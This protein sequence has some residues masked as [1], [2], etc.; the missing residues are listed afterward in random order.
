MPPPSHFLKFLIFFE[1]LSKSV[2]GSIFDR[3]GLEIRILREKLYRTS[4]QIDFSSFFENLV[5]LRALGIGASGLILGPGASGD[6][7]FEP[8]GPRGAL[9]SPGEKFDFS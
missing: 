1:N 7:I 4:V 3:F 8:Q 9:G 2:P 5:F 6:R